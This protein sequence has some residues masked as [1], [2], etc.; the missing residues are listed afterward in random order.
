MSI[1]IRFSLISGQVWLINDQVFC[2][3]SSRAVDFYSL[4]V[5]LSLLLVDV[6]R[7]M[8]VSFIFLDF[9]RF[10]PIFVGFCPFQPI[11]LIFFE[12]SYSYRFADF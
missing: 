6:V 3:F 10:G 4:F 12:V 7:F 11:L 8:S 1:F 9:F 5:D 2:W